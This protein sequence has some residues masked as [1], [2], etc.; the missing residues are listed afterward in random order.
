MRELLVVTVHLHR[1]NFV[2][3]AKDIGQARREMQ[4]VGGKAATV[5][6]W[7][8]PHGEHPVHVEQFELS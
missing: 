8:D 4:R 1:H 6:R 2:T 7:D 5:D 3:A